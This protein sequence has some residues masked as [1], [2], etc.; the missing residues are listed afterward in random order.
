[1][2]QGNNPVLSLRAHYFM[3]AISGLYA[4]AN[5]DCQGINPAVPMYGHLTTYKASVCP[6]C[7]VPLLEIVQCKR[8]GGFVLMGC[9]DSQN[10]KI[11]PCEDGANRDDYF[12]IDLSPEQEV[13][14]TD[15]IKPEL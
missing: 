12:S 2:S 11:F 4:C 10:H 14:E 15:P 8:C 1:M 9:S 5:A 3:R 13:E 6:E 7:G